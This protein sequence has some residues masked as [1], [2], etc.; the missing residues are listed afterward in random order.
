MYQKK[1]F[2]NCNIRPPN[3]II[4]YKICTKQLKNRTQ[5]TCNTKTNG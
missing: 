1:G 3:A 2:L 4:A 5:F